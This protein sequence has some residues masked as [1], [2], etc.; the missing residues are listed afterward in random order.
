MHYRSAQ[1]FAPV[2]VECNAVERKS[3]S[4]GDV[5][6]AAANCSFEA[7]IDYSSSDNTPV[8]ATSQDECCSK[9]SVLAHC[10]AGV[11]VAEDHAASSH[12]VCLCL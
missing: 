7:N 11:F 6:V 10:A 12:A 2:R 8:A 4:D 9:C 3:S 1:W 5:S